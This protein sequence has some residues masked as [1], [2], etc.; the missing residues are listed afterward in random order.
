MHTVFHVVAPYNKELVPI[1]SSPQPH[2]NDTPLALRDVFIIA[3]NTHREAHYCIWNVEEEKF[4]DGNH[5]RHVALV[6]DHPSL[7]LMQ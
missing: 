7:H 1:R 6:P 5:I 3:N 4:P 2:Q